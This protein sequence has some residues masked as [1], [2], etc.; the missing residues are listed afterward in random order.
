VRRESY[1]DFDAI[2]RVQGASLASKV[3]VFDR[4]SRW[5]R[6]PKG[7]IA[8]QPVGKVKEFDRLGLDG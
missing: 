6:L 7:D 3:K 5:T 2:S 1:S 4:R 8:V